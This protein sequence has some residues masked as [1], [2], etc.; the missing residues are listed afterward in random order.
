MK[1]ECSASTTKL[2]ARFQGSQYIRFHA[3]MAVPYPGLITTATVI[4]I[5]LHILGPLLIVSLDILSISSFTI[6]SV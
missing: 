1:S 6:A 2:G 4:N 3:F 5:N